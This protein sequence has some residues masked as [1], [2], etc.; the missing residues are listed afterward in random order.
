MTKQ[1]IGILQGFVLSSSILN[2]PKPLWAMLSSFYDM[3][4][5]LTTEI[6]SLRI[7]SFPIN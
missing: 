2:R 5:F 4:I 3:Y 1:N 7:T 6:N